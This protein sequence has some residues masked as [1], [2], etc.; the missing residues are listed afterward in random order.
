[1]R[2]R[3][4]A[5][6][7]AS[8][9]VA[10]AGACSVVHDTGELKT[11]FDQGVAAYDAGRYDEAFKI[12]KS[13]DEEDVAAMRNEGVMLRE[14]QGT[15]KDPKAAEEML[16]R[17]ADAGLA[18]AQYD[19]AEMLINGEAGAPDPKAALPW[20]TQAAAAHHPIAEYR[21]G[22][23]YEEGTAV[24]KNLGFAR[25]LYADAAARGVPDAKARLDKLGGP[26]PVPTPPPLPVPDSSGIP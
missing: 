14:G 19:L 16:E 24:E 5:A 13:I 4:P 21:L 23:F 25:T 9:C 7:V 6:F 3:L 20:L 11:I 26:P 18:T 15:E 10:F 2:S 17:A 22:L 1:M 12:F 8:L